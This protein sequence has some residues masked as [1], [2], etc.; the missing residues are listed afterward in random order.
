MA[1]P[2]SELKKEWMEIFENLI[3]SKL[4]DKDSRRK[5]INFRN[6]E[7]LIQFNDELQ[8]EPIMGTDSVSLN[9]QTTLSPHVEPKSK[10]NLQVDRNFMQE[11]K[12]IVSCSSQE[13]KKLMPSSI[14]GQKKGLFYTQTYKQL[15]IV[16]LQQLKSHPIIAKTTTTTKGV[17]PI[18]KKTEA[19]GDTNQ[20]QLPQL[21]PADISKY[22]QLFK[23]ADKHNQ[24]QISKIEGL[25]FFA[26]SNLPLELIEQ[27]WTI[28]D[29]DK[30]NKL[31]L[32]EFR[33]AMHLIYH[34]LK[35]NPL[36]KFLSQQ[37]LLSAEITHN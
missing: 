32:Q 34:S 33:L 20:N 17:K 7:P 21:I 27:I 18:P 13:Q 30:D 37:I 15:P 36:P 14:Q 8:F 9:D 25:E 11:A 35:G 23:S 31:K 12:K 5:S 28:S 16:Q 26:S 1:F 24:G 19:I 10:L 3:K 2:T 4:E 22:D 6:D 29:R